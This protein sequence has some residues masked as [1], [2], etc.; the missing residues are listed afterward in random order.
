[1]NFE[2]PNEFYY[3]RFIRACAFVIELIIEEC[4]FHSFSSDITI[5][6]ISAGEVVDRPLNVVKELVENSLDADAKSIS[7]EIEK[8][9]KKL[10]KE[11]TG[12]GLTSFTNLTN[13]SKVSS[14]NKKSSKLIFL[15]IQ[16]NKNIFKYKQIKIGRAS[17]RERV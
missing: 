2:A 8:S 6:K 17:C 1:L 15:V 16:Q 7:I 5:D 10:I 13:S 12:T 9:G 4:A 11:Q 14:N 3:Y